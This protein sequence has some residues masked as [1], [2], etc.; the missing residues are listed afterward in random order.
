MI[1]IIIKNNPPMGGIIVAFVHCIQKVT[2]YSS[3]CV[4]NVRMC[5]LVPVCTWGGK[6]K[7]EILSKIEGFP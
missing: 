6:T 3:E 5:L 1:Y 4:Y 2:P 7:N